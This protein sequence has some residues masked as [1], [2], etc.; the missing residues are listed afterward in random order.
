MSEETT[1]YQRNRETILNRAKKSYSDNKEVLKEKARNK[2]RRLS[3]EKKDTK[4]EY[5]RNR[6]HNIS[7][8][9]KQ[10]LKEYQKNYCEVKKSN[11]VV[12]ILIKYFF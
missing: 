3:E 1:Y 2:Y 7:E 8:E 9:K 4:R 12:N 10:R 11:L 5:G 6:Y